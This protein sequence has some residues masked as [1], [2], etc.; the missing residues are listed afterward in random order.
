MQIEFSRI[1]FS[2]VIKL[3]IPNNWQI[4]PDTT[5]AHTT[6]TLNPLFSHIFLW[7]TL[8]LRTAFPSKPYRKSFSFQLLKAYVPMHAMGT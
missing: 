6:R 7:K 8:S 3:V 5:R 1:S 2:W 4:L